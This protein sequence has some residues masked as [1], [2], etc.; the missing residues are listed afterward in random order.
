MPEP[1]DTPAPATPEA[2]QQAQDALLGARW[3]GWAARNLTIDGG[4]VQDGFRVD[5]DRLRET[6]HKIDGV[7]RNLDAATRDLQSTVV[8]PPGYDEISLNIARNATAMRDNAVTYVKTWRQQVQDTRD[9]LGQSLTAYEATE[10][11][12]TARRA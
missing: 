4:S 10:S 6:V 5:P 3:R 12:N 11:A 9:A 8:E 1:R 7:L 2:E